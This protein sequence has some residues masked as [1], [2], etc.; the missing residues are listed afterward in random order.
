MLLRRLLLLSVLLGL[1]VA[2]LGARATPAANPAAFV[3]TLVQQGIQLITEQLPEQ[4]REQRFSALLRDGFD[5]PRIARFVLGRYWISVSDQDRQQFANLYEEWNVKIYSVR[6]R[7]YSG[8]TVK[9]EGTKPVS[10]EV[11]LVTSEISWPN[12]PPVKVDWRV[13]ADNGDYK[14]VDVEV[15]GV[16]MALA[17]RDEFASVIQQNGGTVAGLNRALEARLASGD[18]GDRASTR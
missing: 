9:V 10:N 18:L 15:E 6:F 1:A 13:R 17:Q 3:N 16:S 8:Q 5:I 14:I 11:T 4:Q 7:D 2:P 12:G